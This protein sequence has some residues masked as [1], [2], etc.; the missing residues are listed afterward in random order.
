MP[1]AD[2]FALPRA[3]GA[4]A[5]AS[6]APGAATAAASPHAFC[7]LVAGAPL[8]LWALVAACLSLFCAT[9]L[10]AAGAPPGT[11]PAG[12]VVAPAAWGA[13]FLVLLVVEASAFSTLA[14]GLVRATPAGLR[15]S[16]SAARRAAGGGSVLRVAHETRRDELDPEGFRR[17][18]E[19]SVR[20]IQHAI[21]ALIAKTTAVAAG[22]ATAATAASGAV[23][24]LGGVLGARAD[25]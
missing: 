17:D 12:A 13:F 14:G 10:A 1:I 16:T 11:A 20:R 15:S 5:T 21:G 23:A 3:P 2:I 24:V 7:A 25:D 9:W 22:W 6:D 19:R 8:A 4:A 18:V